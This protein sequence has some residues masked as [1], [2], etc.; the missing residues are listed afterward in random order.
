MTTEPTE[1]ESGGIPAVPDLSE[2]IER[3][4]AHPEIIEMAASVLGQPPPA[5]SASAEHPDSDEQKTSETEAPKEAA[6]ASAEVGAGSMSDALPELLKLVTP[7]LQKG[8]GKHGG[9]SHSEHSKGIGRSTALLLAL[10]PYLSP[11]RC[12]AVDKIVQMSKL[13]EILEKL[14]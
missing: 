4:M 5:A 10:K 1:N 12:A 8:G 11:Q 2:A 14:S 7:L 6:G 3:L 9:H 13:G